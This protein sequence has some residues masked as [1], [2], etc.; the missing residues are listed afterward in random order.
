MDGLEPAQQA[1]YVEM[2]VIMN[3]ITQLINPPP[4]NRSPNIRLFL[5]LCR[6]FLYSILL[7]LAKRSSFQSQTVLQSQIRLQLYCISSQGGR[8]TGTKAAPCQ[9]VAQG[10]FSSIAQVLGLIS[11]H[12]SH[13]TGL[14]M[15][16]GLCLQ[17][18]LSCLPLLLFLDSEVFSL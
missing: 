7:L 11:K 13:Q 10:H 16:M 1:I 5:M 2:S 14:Q 9:C 3:E 8:G 18:S 6:T 17:V 12:D 4:K 15:Q